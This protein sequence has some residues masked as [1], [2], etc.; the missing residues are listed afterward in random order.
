ML[1]HPTAMRCFH[2]PPRKAHGSR[3]WAWE[4]KS[5]EPYDVP[6]H[7]VAMHHFHGPPWKAHGS[8]AWE[9][10]SHEPH[11]L[12]LAK[13]NIHTDHTQPQAPWSPM[14]PHGLHLAIKNIHPDHTQTPSLMERHG[15]LIGHTNHAP[16]L[17]LVYMSEMKQVPK[18]L[19]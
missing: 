13:Q 10:K 11:G 3:A 4:P 12:H 15:L 6:L 8:R 2:G 18:L 9:P 5:H 1:L 16:V 7:P 19:K 14:E 17:E